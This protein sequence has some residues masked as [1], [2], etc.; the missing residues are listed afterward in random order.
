MHA[1]QISYKTLAGIFSEINMVRYNGSSGKEATCQCSLALHCGSN[2][3][4]FDSCV[5]KISQRGAWKPTP[6]SLP[7]ESHG[8]RSLVDYSP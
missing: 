5:R 2:H 6:V 7:G 8:Q 3:S 1:E 4:A